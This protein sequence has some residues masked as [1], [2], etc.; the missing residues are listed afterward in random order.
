[1]LGAFRS[2]LVTPDLRRKILFTLG[3]LM[4]Y[5]AGATLPS[6]G[7]SYVNIHQCLDQ[8]QHGAN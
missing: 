2:A 7:V 6:P 3:M 5:R 8:V 1:M 4:I